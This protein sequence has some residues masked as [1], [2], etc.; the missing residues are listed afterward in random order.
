MTD[1]EEEKVVL[2]KL[3][4]PDDMVKYIKDNL[5]VV[6]SYRSIYDVNGDEINVPVTMDLY[7]GDELISEG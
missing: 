5:R 4:S 2:K 3:L 7:F 6:C 1:S